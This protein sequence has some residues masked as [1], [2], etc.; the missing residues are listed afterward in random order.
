MSGNYV[1]ITFLE[2]KLRRLH[3]R[4]KREVV[5]T[6]NS[7]NKVWSDWYIRWMWIVIR[8]RESGGGGGNTGMTV[9]VGCQLVRSGSADEQVAVGWWWLWP[10]R[11]SSPTA[12]ENAAGVRRSRLTGHGILPPAS[13]SS[14]TAALP[15]GALRR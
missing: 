13:L 3:R 14:D 9:G 12:F 11:G 6:E 15:S 8:E 7:C 5:F 4:S 1:A 10:V 2:T